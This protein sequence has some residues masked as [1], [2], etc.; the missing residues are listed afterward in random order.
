MAS[1]W[2]GVASSVVSDCVGRFGVMN[3]AI[4][5]LT[6][7]SA[8]GPAYTVEL[9]PG[10]NLTLH[11]ELARVPAGSILVVD[12]GGLTERAVWGEVMTIAAM[13]RGLRGV[14]IDGAI[15]D[16]VAIS[17]LG[18]PVFARGT[19]PA[20][21]HKS[22]GGRAGVAISCGG[23]VVRPGDLIVADLDGVAVV[24][25]DEAE[26]V[27]ADVQQRLAV[28][29]TWIGRIREGHSSVEVLGLLSGRGDDAAGADPRRG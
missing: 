14:V 24:A 16:I 17:A 11:Q 7:R 23:A 1:N 5:S 13:E 3:S 18:F 9:M 25:A 6:G 29:Q 12:A 27:F 4:R 8:H 19:V 20:G 22:G 28:E 15:R 26:A 21:P 2:E 10:D